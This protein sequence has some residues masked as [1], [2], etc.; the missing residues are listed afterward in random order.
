MLIVEIRVNYEQIGVETA[1]CI[2]GDTGENSI[3]TYLL[4]SNGKEIKHR[5]GDGAAALAKKMMDNLVKQRRDRGI[6]AH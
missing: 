5:Y 4:G 1:V 2:K 3:N 6:L